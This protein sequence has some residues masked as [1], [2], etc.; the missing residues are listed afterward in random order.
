ML[1]R[2]NGIL[3]KAIQSKEKTTVAGEKEQIQ[4]EVLGSHE[5]DG[6][7]LV[8]NVNSNIKNHIS[9]VSTDDATEFP[10]T[11]TY[12]ATGNKYKVFG[13]GSVENKKEIVLPEGLQIGSTVKYVPTGSTYN[14]Q[15][16]YCSS[17]K[18]IGD[19]NVT[20]DSTSSGSY[21]ITNW[22]IFKIDYEEGE[23]QLV[24]AS[25]RGLVYLGQEQGYNNGVKLLN[26]ACSTLYSH[27][28]KGI[29]ARSIRMEDIEP[30]LDETK[31]QAA[32]DDYNHNNTSSK[33][34]LDENDQVTNPYISPRCY[35]P[36]IYEQE[37]NS[38]INGTK[39][40]SGLGLSDTPSTFFGR[41]DA[42]TLEENQTTATN[43]T[44]GSLIAKTSIQP[45][46]T[47]YYWKSALS[48]SGNYKDST[49]AS[50]YTSMLNKTFWVASR[51]VDTYYN[52]CGFCMRHVTEG[53]LDGGLY[54]GYLYASNSGIDNRSKALFPVV[55]LNSDLIKKN[56]SGFM[57]E[58]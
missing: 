3:Q 27:S 16:E 13:D 17:T 5:N 31:L 41:T 11:V 52:Y 40:A 45:Y 15:A 18:T 4:L 54:T 19:D 29:T 50:A 20:L 30:L 43:A 25:T 57:V 32:K 21:R 8:E 46:Q 24:P 26:D 48:T 47:Y 56:E 36:L 23:I 2:D 1:S 51:C 12:T 58:L 38:V 6:T 39:K 49:T 34:H 9:G 44:N 35:Y 22:K 10:L 55:C 42:T 28:S 33:G 14:W 37:I 53:N 7:L